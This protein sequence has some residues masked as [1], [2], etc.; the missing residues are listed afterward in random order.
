MSHRRDQIR[1]QMQRHLDAEG[2]TRRQALDREWLEAETA[3]K[4][5]EADLLQFWKDQA[6]KRG[7]RG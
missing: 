6:R 4:P 7:G 1:R 2:Q 3:K 5:T